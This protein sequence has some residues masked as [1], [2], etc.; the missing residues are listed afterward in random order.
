[1]NAALGFEK[2]I[3]PN[4]LMTRSIESD[5]NAWVWASPCTE[6]RGF[7]H[8]VT[9]VV[10]IFTRDFTDAQPDAQADRLF[11]G[12]VVALD[13]L[14]HPNRVRQRGRRRG[15]HDHEPVAQILHLGAAGLATACRRIEKCSRR[16]SSAASGARPA[17][18]TVE[19]TMSVNKTAT[20]SVVTAPA[21]QSAGSYGKPC[22]VPT[23]RCSTSAT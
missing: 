14:L 3:V 1:M 12:A 22:G 20:F 9:E 10:V 2:N 23:A 16:N 21:S 7:D 5:S 13:A 19:P 18:K 6:S 4:R 15:E 11:P 17:A 8:R